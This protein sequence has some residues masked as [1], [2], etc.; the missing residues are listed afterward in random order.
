MNL[1]AIVISFLRPEY[2]MECV[3]S[4]REQ[5][6][7]IEIFVGE[8]AEYNQKLKDFVKKHG[9]RYFLLPYD[10][11]VTGGRNR[12]IEL[13][14]TDYVLVGDDD[15]YYTDTANVDKMLSF[16]QK[17]PEYDVIGGSIEE[18]GQVKHYEGHIDLNDDHYHYRPLKPDDSIK[19]EIEW[20]DCDITFNYFVARTASVEKWDENIKVAYE[21]S[22]WFITMKKAGKK[23]AFTPDA[24][25]VH[26]PDHVKLTREQRNN[27]KTFRNRKSDKAYYYKKH[28]IDYAIAFNGVKAFKN[29]MRLELPEREEEQRFT[30]GITHFMRKESLERLILSISKHYKQ[31]EIIIA[32]TSTQFDTQ[33]YKQL[34]QKCNF[35]KKPV[36]YRLQEDAGLSAMRNFIAT[37][38]KTPYILYLED[39]FEW[40]EKTDPHS[41]LKPMSNRLVAVVGGQVEEKDTILNFHGRLTRKGD[42]MRL[43]KSDEPNFVLNF[44][45]VRKRSMIDCS[46]DE[47]FKVYEHTDYFYRLNK[48]KWKVAYTEDSTIFHHRDRPANY[49]EYRN[50]QDFLIEFYRKHNLRKLIQFGKVMEYKEKT[51]KIKT[52]YEATR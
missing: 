22:D 25:V 40:T 41:M 21:H 8:N 16:L 1:T 24:L 42:I 52:Y 49:K 51:K 38:A 37:M 48:T 11:G 6:P 4:L 47:R 46:W 15:F 50:R 23:V 18:H 43:D 13:V 12:L 2:T 39:D 44:I 9:G 45:M 20:Y 10:S 3:R 35:D 27:Y 30:I 17:R 29:T 19:E 5:Y 36:A 28:K 31:A 26:K 34:W 7:N 32:D 33:F 14:E